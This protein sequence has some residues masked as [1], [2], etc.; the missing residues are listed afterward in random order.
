ML[1]KTCKAVCQRKEEVHFTPEVGIVQRICCPTSRLADKSPRRFLKVVVDCNVNFDELLRPN[2][3]GDL[4][5]IWWG[6]TSPP[7]LPT[8]SIPALG[9]NR[10]WEIP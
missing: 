7:V 5:E 10:K 9:G 3:Q 6:T 1:M 2:V 8:I 4:D